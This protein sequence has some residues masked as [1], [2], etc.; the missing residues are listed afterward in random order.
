[1]HGFPNRKMYLSFVSLYSLQ[2]HTQ[3]PKAS[4]VV[5]TCNWFKVND[6]KDLPTNGGR[7]V[8]KRKEKKQRWSL[9]FSPPAS[10]VVLQTLSKA[11]DLLVEWQRETTLTYLIGH[12]LS[13]VSEMLTIFICIFFLKQWLTFD[14]FR[15]PL[16]GA[17]EA[18]IYKKPP[19]LKS[20]AS[21]RFWKR[22]N[23]SRS[24]SRS[25]GRSETEEV[26]TSSEDDI[27]SISIDDVSSDEEEDDDDEVW[28]E[29]KES[30]EVGVA[31]HDTVA[32][33]GI[34][35]PVAIDSDADECSSLSSELSWFQQY[36]Y[37]E[38]EETSDLRYLFSV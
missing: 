32:D 24:P 27:S 35:E 11:Q 15:G 23:R 25:V 7:I 16:P 12:F 1:M 29:V 6:T 10:E 17:P 20:K 4:K 2:K 37:Y 28:D 31:N 18:S 9:F 13:I 22:K 21:K 3:W 5:H 33:D 36:Y 8:L 19:A 38:D 26:Y 14:L 30:V 34:D